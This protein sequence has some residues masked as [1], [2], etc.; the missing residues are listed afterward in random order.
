MASTVAGS[1]DIRPSTGVYA[2]YR[3]LSYKPW[4]AIAE[5]VDNSTQSYFDHREEL[6][7]AYREANDKLRVDASYDADEETLTVYDNAFGM[8]MV[9]FERALVLDSPP[10]NRSGRSEFGMGLKTAASWFGTIWMVET[11]QLGSPRMLSAIVDVDELAEQRPE[12]LPFEETP[13]D[14]KEHFTRLTI[15]QVRHPVRGRTTGRV[16]DQLGSMYRQDLRS[17]EIRITWNGQPVTFDEAPILTQT[18]KDGARRT[19]REE[20]AFTVEHP[21]NGEALPV[22]GWIA[23]RDPGKQRDAGLVLLRRNRVI[24]GGRRRGTGPWRCSGSRTCTVPNG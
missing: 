2:T 10:Q 7:V 18:L 13:V 3:R 24:M 22:R 8:E 11:T 12:T 9:D 5:F 14:P 4:F 19:W 1:I 6:L 15:S 16:L 21:F 20:V 17:G 23:L